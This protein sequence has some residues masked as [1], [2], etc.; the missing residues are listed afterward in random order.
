MGSKPD[1][2]ALQV[3]TGSTRPE[4]PRPGEGPKTIVSGL[5][6]NLIPE[7][8][9]V[10]CEVES[11]RPVLFPVGSVCPRVSVQVGS[12]CPCVSFC[13]GGFGVSSRLVCLGSGG[14]LTEARKERGSEPSGGD[15]DN[16]G[17]EGHSCS[18]QFGV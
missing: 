1:Q 8:T 14:V 12:N 13:W 10:V 4:E 5:R 15:A 2:G 6:V 16:A 7:W 11:H 18:W 17:D 9:Q 3:L